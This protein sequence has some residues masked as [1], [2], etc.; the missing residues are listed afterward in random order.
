MEKYKAPKLDDA[1]GDISKRWRVQYHF[2][3]P[4]T[5]KFERFQVTV[6]SRLRTKSS[7][8]IKAREL[9][10]E[11]KIKLKK[12]WSPYEEK[13][14]EFSTII[15]AIEQVLILK[16]RTTRPVTYRTYKNLVNP[17]IAW[18]KDKKLHRLT[19]DEINYYHASKYTDFLLMS[20]KISART[21]NNHLRALRNIFN[22][23]IKRE[24]TSVNPFQ[25]ID[26]LPATEAEIVAF[27]PKEL[28]I[29]VN[30]LPEYN[31]DLYVGA[32]MVYYCFMRPVEIMRIKIGDIDI[33]NRI[34]V[35]RGAVAK[36]KSQQTI[37]I[38]T[39][40]LKVFLK[41]DTLEYPR[42]WHLFDRHLKPSVKE[43]PPT[44][45]AE[46]WRKFAKNR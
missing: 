29:V 13:D 28:A 16:Q 18:L 10:N 4:D 19:V 31:Y 39:L 42:N 8:Y 21:F 37:R 46:Q 15:G 14:P 38:P 5:N 23:F 30:E 33:R 26:H 6:S 44:R 36:N 7:R 9:M 25:K 11:I 24:L 17:F 34:I 40:M 35:V 1:G 3:N 2:R 20:K 41:W 43:F 27:T 12:G 45:L 22:I 32:M